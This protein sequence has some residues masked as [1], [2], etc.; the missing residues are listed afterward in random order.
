M[1]KTRLTG[2]AAALTALASL[3]A[4]G[5]GGAGPEAPAT[6][7]SVGAMTIN[8]SNY[9]QVMSDT[10][11]AA[12]GAT[13][14]S[15]VSTMVPFTPDSTQ[16]MQPVAAT[17][18]SITADG[19]AQG[20]Q[21]QYCSTGSVDVAYTDTNRNGVQDEGDVMV[22]RFVSCALPG[23]AGSMLYQVSGKVTIKLNGAAGPMDRNFGLVFD[24]FKIES[25]EFAGTVNGAMSYLL[26]PNLE[27]IDAPNLRLDMS[28]AG[29]SR[30]DSWTDFKY[31]VVA[32]DGVSMGG[33]VRVAFSGQLMSSAFGNKS[34]ELSTP[35]PIEF[36]GSDEAPYQGRMVVKGAGGATASA[37]ADRNQAVTLAV[38]ANGDR[39]MDRSKLV[40]WTAFSG[41]DLP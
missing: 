34:V 23:Q 37:T 13:Q 17:A 8:E 22:A 7:S 35:T 20:T 32:L 16:W 25:V 27:R 12:M 28:D 39:V 24:D 31:S 19:S 40:S 21:S 1:N 9:E 38:D 6:P 11:V 5:G 26:Q 41:T 36:A 14:P 30:T 33:A 3:T 15:G 4:C 2:M 10:M 29:K 18:A